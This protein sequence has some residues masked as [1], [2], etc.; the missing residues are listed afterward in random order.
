MQR[1]QF[2]ENVQSLFDR[3]FVS[4]FA[5][6]LTQDYESTEKTLNA[7][8]FLANKGLAANLRLFVLMLLDPL[9]CYGELVCTSEL[10]ED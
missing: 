3:L 8:I 9:D 6:M 10:F 4:V 2:L 1:E 5:R 7:G